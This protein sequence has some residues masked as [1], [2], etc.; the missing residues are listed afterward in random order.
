MLFVKKHVHGKGIIDTINP[1]LT[2]IAPYI[3]AAKKA[4]DVIKNVTETVKD[5]N[6]IKNSIREMRKKKSEEPR[7]GSGFRYV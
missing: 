7:Q 3:L 4:G 2:N 6:K 1:I 5:L